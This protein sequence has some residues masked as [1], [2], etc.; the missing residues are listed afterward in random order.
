[1][2]VPPGCPGLPDRDTSLAAS[3]APGTCLPLSACTGRRSRP[4]GFAPAGCPGLA[5][6]TFGTVVTIDE[7]GSLDRVKDVSRIEC[8]PS[9]APLER[10]VA[11][12]G[13]R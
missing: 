13:A 2:P 6:E 4:H 10:C 9:R 1:V 5:P 3:P 12:D 7:H 11:C 8:A